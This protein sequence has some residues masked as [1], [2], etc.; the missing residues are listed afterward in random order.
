MIQSLSQFEVLPNLGEN[1][2]NKSRTSLVYHK[3]IDDQRSLGSAKPIRLPLSY[4]AKD[5]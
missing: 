2:T 5:D 4:E 3:Q 1:K